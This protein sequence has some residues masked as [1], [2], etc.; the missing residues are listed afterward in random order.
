MEQSSTRPAQNPLRAAISPEPSLKAYSPE[1]ADSVGGCGEAVAYA[2][3]IGCCCHPK[4]AKLLHAKSL[5]ATSRDEPRLATLFAAAGRVQRAPVS[6]QLEGRV[7]QVLQALEERLLRCAAAH[8]E[9]GQ[10]VAE[11]IVGTSQRVRNAKLLRSPVPNNWEAEL[12]V[13]EGARIAK[14]LRSTRASSP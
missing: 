8:L 1:P 13:I 14:P 9:M 12:D 11:L 10:H 4:T 7:A 2:A 5:R 3:G 6:R